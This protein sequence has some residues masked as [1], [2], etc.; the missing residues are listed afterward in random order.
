[1]SRLHDRIWNILWDILAASLLTVSVSFL[2]AETMVPGFR[3]RL[4]L[5]GC[6]VSCVLLVLMRHF[7]RGIWR[8]LSLLAAVIAGVVSYY[9]KG[10][11]FE[12]YQAFSALFVSIDRRTELAL[13]YSPEIQILLCLVPALFFVPLVKTDDGGTCLFFFSAVCFVPW[14]LMYM[15]DTG[16]EAPGIGEALRIMIPGAAGVIMVMGAGS[17]RRLS[18]I[19]LAAA[20]AAITIFFLPLEGTVSPGM[21]DAAQRLTDYGR[22]IFYTGEDRNAFS[23]SSSGYMPLEDRLGGSVTQKFV[24]VMRIKT[25][26]A[27]AVYLKGSS[28]DTY[29]GISWQDTLSERGYLYDGPLDF[30]KRADVFDQGMDSG[31]TVRSLTVTMLRD[32]TSTVFS[33]QRILSFTGGSDRMVLYC[34]DAGDL[35]I[36]RDLCSGDTY[37][38]TWTDPE[39]DPVSLRDRVLS[40]EGRRDGKWD[41]ICE[42]YL[43]VSPSVAQEV[44]SLTEGIVSGIT[45][46]YDRAAALRDH[47]MDHYVYSLKTGTP[48]ADEDFVSWFLLREGKGYCA[49]FA[50]AMTVMCRIAGIPARYVTGYAVVPSPDGTAVIDTS[51]GHA[52]TEI[53]LKGFGWLTVD[54]TAHV[55][56]NSEA[57]GSGQ[58][59]GVVYDR[60]TPAPTPG[61][62]DAAGKG[63]EGGSSFDV[64]S[65]TPGPTGHSPTPSGTTSV[66]ETPTPAPTP[67]PRIDNGENTETKGKGSFL[68]P[69]LAVLVLLAFL[70]YLRLRLRDPVRMAEKD[71]SNAARIYYEASWDICFLLYGKK[72]EDMTWSEYGERMNDLSDI[73]DV[74]KAAEDYASVIYGKDRKGDMALAGP[75]YRSLWSRCGIFLKAWILIKRIFT[76]G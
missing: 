69:I 11:V 1:M 70:I 63:G 42:T 46:P 10:I 4:I 2:W 20:I 19:P 32:E 59:G 12:Y 36:T 71:P 15:P 38:L 35:Y 60:P 68:L 24:P 8:P 65:P 56:G 66:P 57:D 55:P 30:G 3:P 18:L 21:H 62:E 67:A 61:P 25:D 29:T 43:T 37:T 48:A 28:C 64:E 54:A 23:L 47:L 13:W 51:M 74:E 72:P 34:S 7:I 9:I 52:W 45:E 40:C 39:D 33:P 16:I 22:D 5:W 73:R 27:G 53:Y 6:L 75:L 14:S 17:G 58:S 31:G 41:R 49:Y 50:S 76:I 26:A 44:L